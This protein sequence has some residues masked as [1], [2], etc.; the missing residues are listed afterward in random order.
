MRANRGYCR[1]RLEY[2]EYDS[3]FPI[4]FVLI[5][6]VSALWKKSFNLVPRPSHNIMSV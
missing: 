1:I 5:V 6:C 3:P 2:C 4:L